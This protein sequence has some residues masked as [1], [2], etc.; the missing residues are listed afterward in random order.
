MKILEYITSFNTHTRTMTH[1]YKSI[2]IVVDFPN[3]ILAVFNN[4][5]LK[6]KRSIKDMSLNEYIDFI[7]KVLS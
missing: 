5:I 6:T 3:E 4:N 1:R 7:N 2:S